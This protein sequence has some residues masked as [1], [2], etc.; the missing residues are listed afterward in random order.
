M[1]AH[2][3]SVF[4]R[5]QWALSLA[6]LFSGIGIAT[7]FAVGGILAER[8]TGRTELAG[9]AQTASI[10]GAGLLAVPLAKV[11]EHR[12]RRLALASAYA[13]ALCGAVLIV[14]AILFEFDIAFFIG[15]GCFGAAT[16]AGLQGRYA[17][18][19]A[20][21]E[22]LKGS[23][24]SVV[25]WATTIGSVI[26]PNL[27]GPGADL[28]RALSLDPLSGPFVIA[29]AGFG[30]AL[31]SVLFL[32]RLTPA[33]R[34]ANSASPRRGGTWEAIRRSPSALMGLLSVV[35]GHMIMVATMVM[36][37]LHM[38]HHGLGLELIGI[39]IGGHILGMYGLSPVFGYLTDR[40]SA[41]R[42]ILF[43]H[44]LF[45]VSLVLGLA[46]ALG[47]SSFIRLSA[48]LFVLG[49]GWSACLI[50]GST[51]LTKEID[52]E[53]RMSVQGLSDAGMNF[54]AAALAAASGPLLAFG[55]F[56][57]ITLMGFVVL[58]VAVVFSI[59]A[60]YGTRHST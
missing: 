37:P 53:H 5:N 23:A 33:T 4:R 32:R 17:A 50:A 39:T 21:P 44:G 42:V 38:D 34:D 14:L 49:L 7:G 45:A 16:A 11:A 46:D 20:A 13:I 6:Q 24:M 29:I 10:L 25:V 22:H 28:G 36:T 59:R 19:D 12:S 18:T 35:T 55:G 47:E 52:P 48:A 56:A 57:A 60:R 58:A 43:G 8:L 3:Q 1:P 26:G 30:L 31:L 9:F 27:S 41:G 51:L 2:P 40:Y 54:G 15:M